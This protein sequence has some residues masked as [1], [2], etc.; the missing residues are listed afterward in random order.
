MVGERV[1]GAFINFGVFGR[2]DE[3]RDSELNKLFFCV[4]KPML[5]VW[6]MPPHTE[7]APKLFLVGN[8]DFPSGPKK[9]PAHPA[10]GSRPA[11]VT[12][13]TFS[14]NH[15]PPEALALLVHHPA[16]P[17]STSLH[18][19]G[20][21]PSSATT[22]CLRWTPQPPPHTVTAYMA[23]HPGVSPSTSS[24]GDNRAL[25]PSLDGIVVILGTHFFYSRTFVWIFL[26][27]RLFFRYFWKKMVMIFW[28]PHPSTKEVTR[29]K[30]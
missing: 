22:R 19:P 23:D 30:L 29:S 20:R 21:S 7:K 25:S 27:L 6:V 3:L 14:C 15:S 28:C 24:R 17:C 18:R 26:C 13:H 9:F 10:T 11:R 2:L 8:L 4:C 5:G 16:P 12:A 1:H